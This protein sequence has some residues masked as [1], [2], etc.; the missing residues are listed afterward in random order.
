MGSSDLQVIGLLV[1]DRTL[2]TGKHLKSILVVAKKIMEASVIAS[3]GLQLGVTDETVLPFW[4]EPY[5]SVAM[6]ER[7]LLRFPEL[8]VEEHMEVWYG[9]V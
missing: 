8:Y 5:H 9:Y 4:K 1:G 2:R 6:M 3:E 7:L